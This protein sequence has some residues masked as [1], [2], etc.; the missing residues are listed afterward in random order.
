MSRLLL[1]L[2]LLLLLQLLLLLLLQLLLLLML[3]LLPLC[4]QFPCRLAFAATAAP[5]GTGTAALLHQGLV[6][7]DGLV[8]E[9]ILAFRRNIS[10]SSMAAW[11]TKATVSL[12]AVVANVKIETG[13]LA[14]RCVARRLVTGGTRSNL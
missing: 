14:V 9:V 7:C 11:A 10:A 3:L 5:T 12:A 13:D 6:F 1:L 4:Q 2:L 8:A